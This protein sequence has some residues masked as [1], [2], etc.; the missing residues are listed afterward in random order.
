MSC[1]R[2][3]KDRNQLQRMQYSFKRWLRRRVEPKGGKPS[4]CKNNTSSYLGTDKIA[5]SE[6]EKR[7][8]FWRIK[9]GFV[10][11]SCQSMTC[12]QEK[13]IIPIFHSGPY[14]SVMHQFTSE[15][16]EPVYRNTLEQ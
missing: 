10:R 7:P 15:Y 9:K 4:H 5:A 11:T 1:F 2:L 14:S 13:E 16:S 6:G 12:T 8:I 3:Q